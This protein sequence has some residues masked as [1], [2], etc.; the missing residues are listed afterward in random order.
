VPIYLDDFTVT[1][2][3]V[4]ACLDQTF[5]AI[6][7]LAT[8]G[9]MVSLKKSIICAGQGK[10]L[11]QRWSSGGYFRADDKQLKAVLELPSHSLA[12]I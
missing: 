3:E 10:V 12:G 4:E 9:A 2:D 6:R 11:G 7:R 1:S 5:E 8:A